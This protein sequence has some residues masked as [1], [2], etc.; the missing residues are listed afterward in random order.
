MNWPVKSGRNERLRWRQVRLR[1]LTK[2]EQDTCSTSFMRTTV[3]NSSNKLNHLEGLRGVAAFVVLLQHMKLSFFDGSGTAATE[4]VS[5]AAGGAIGVLLTA[6]PRALF[7]GDFA[8]WIFWVMSAFVLSIKFHSAD[9]SKANSFLTQST[10]RR[11]PRLLPPVLLTVMLTW[12][13]HECGLMSNNQLADALGAPQGSWLGALYQ[14]QPD[15]I[16]AANSGLWQSFFAYQPER[17][18]NVV[19][20]TMEIEVYGSFFLFAFLALLGKH[21]SRALGY[22]AASAILF[23]LN[24]IWP[25]AFLLGTAACDAY[26]H[27]ESLASRLPPSV[28]TMLAKFVNNVPAFA[29]VMLLTLLIVGLPNYL[30]V[31]NLLVATALTSYVACSPVAKKYFAIRPFVFLGKI[32]FGLYLIHVPII[33]VLAHPIYALSIQVLDRGPASLV[34]CLCITIASIGGGWALW[35]AGDRPAVTF[36]RWVSDTLEWRSSK[37]ELKVVPFS[38]DGDQQERRAA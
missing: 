18:Y 25:V 38:A 30:G 20:W 28:T 8:V 11:Y 26:V 16:V 29:A 19:L 2:A 5:R 34:S 1:F 33:C 17:T 32:S 31:V 22:L 21:P 3:A 6:P 27:R 7:D 12:L 37:P 23:R 14:F 4:T 10:I 9:K 35:Y 15:F 13:V 36:S 24:L